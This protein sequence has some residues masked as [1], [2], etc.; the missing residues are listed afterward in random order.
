MSENL[1]SG[2]SEC[3]CAVEKRHLT[4]PLPFSS[5]IPLLNR[6]LPVTR[7]LIEDDIHLL[8]HNTAS[9]N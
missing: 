2:E 7:F 6:N 3:V 9:C 5:G 4:A 1:S 8:R